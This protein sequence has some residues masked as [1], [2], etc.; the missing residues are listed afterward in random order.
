[1]G[2]GRE[3]LSEDNESGEK[4]RDH[5]AIRAEGSFVVQRRISDLLCFSCLNEMDVAD[6]DGDPGEQTKT[7]R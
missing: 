7:C 4:Q 5:G 3:I 6:Q 2:E 1:M